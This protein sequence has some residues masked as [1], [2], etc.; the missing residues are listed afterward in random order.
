MKN[1]DQEVKI[2]MDRPLILRR[3]RLFWW[4]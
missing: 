4:I 3:E 1:E 2:E